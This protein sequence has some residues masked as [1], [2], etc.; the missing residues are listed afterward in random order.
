MKSVL[1]IAGVL[2]LVM[3]ASAMSPARAQQRGAAVMQ[4]ADT[5]G[6]GAVS[7]E[8][9]LAARTQ[10]FTRRDRNQDGFLDAADTGNRAATRPRQAMADRMQGRMDNNGD[11]KVSKEEFLN[12][13][14]TM[15]DR[16][17]KDRNGS[18]DAKE[19]QTT[20][21]SAVSGAIL[22]EAAPAQ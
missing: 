10:Q 4:A 15:F 12:L 8:E 2:L 17:D 9:F 22:D 18:I 11:G 21:S 3:L 19:S 6:D 20:E 13:A 14:L 16:M 1:T 5:N 7:R